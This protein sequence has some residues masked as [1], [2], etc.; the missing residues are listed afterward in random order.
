MG[1]R[2]VKME[3]TRLDAVSLLVGLDNNHEWTPF[4]IN[5][6]LIAGSCSSSEFACSN[7]NCV[8]FYY[9]CNSV[10][11]CSDGSDEVGCELAADLPA[12]YVFFISKA[13]VQI[14]TLSA[15]M[16]TVCL[17]ISCAMA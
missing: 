10:T 12:S 13:S 17:A 4:L 16:G 7:G 6:L 11:D 9:D 8:P 15:T 3:K 5:N 14:M 2:T 1:T